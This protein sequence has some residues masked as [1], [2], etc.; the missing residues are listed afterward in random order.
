ME[1]DKQEIFDQLNTKVM[2]YLDTLNNQ[3]PEEI[4]DTEPTSSDN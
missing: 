3:E 4:V 1:Y 2:D